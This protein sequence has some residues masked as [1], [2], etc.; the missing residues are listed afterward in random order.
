MVRQKTMTQTSNF[1]GSFIWKCRCEN[2]TTIASDLIKQTLC[3]GDIA[4]SHVNLESLCAHPSRK[5]AVKNKEDSFAG[6][7]Q[8]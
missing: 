4:R 3:R 2:E 6:M 5:A 7:L 8:P 1:P